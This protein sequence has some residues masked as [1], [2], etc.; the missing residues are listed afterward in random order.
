MTPEEMKRTMD[1]ILQT[2]ADFWAGLQELKA[3]HKDLARH[4][5]EFARMFK[6]LSDLIVIESERL[7]RND[8]EHRKF[9]E[10]MERSD[11]RHEELRQ[12]FLRELRRLIDRLPPNPDSRQN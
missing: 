12:D 9:V 7:D 1:F 11:K 5:K 2:S 6:M 3:L 10:N 8:A 4:D